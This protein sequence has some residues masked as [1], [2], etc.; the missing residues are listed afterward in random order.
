MGLDIVFWDD[1]VLRDWPG[2]V[3]LDSSFDD[4]SKAH[5]HLVCHQGSLFFVC[6][7]PRSGRVWREELNRVDGR[8]VT[9]RLEEEKKK[10]TA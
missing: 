9:C 8:R 1:E 7:S 4:R 6:R 10:R 3:I 5:R 2:A